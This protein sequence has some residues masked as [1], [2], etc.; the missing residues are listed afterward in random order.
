MKR[1]G[2]GIGVDTEVN[3]K[4][5]SVIR[6]YYDTPFG[7]VAMEVLTNNIVNNIERRK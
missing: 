3:L 6:G 4:R 5:E 7:S 2:E 1:Y